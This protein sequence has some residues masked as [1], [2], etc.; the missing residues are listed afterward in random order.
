MAQLFGM[1]EISLRLLPFLCG[2]ALLPLAWAVARRVLAPRFALLALSMIVISPALVRESNNVKQYG[3]DAAIA[4][5][6][7]L[8]ALRTLQRPSSRG[9]WTLIVAAS[10]ACICSMTGIFVVAPA[11]LVLAYHHWRRG[12][13]ALARGFA[14]V[15]VAAMALTLVPYVRLYRVV[16][17]SQYMQDFWRGS[18]VSLAPFSAKSNNAMI[19][20]DAVWAFLASGRPLARGNAE[21]TVAMHFVTVAVLG[22]AAVGAF[23]LLGKK[24]W[25]TIVM[26]APLVLV[27][28]ASISGFYPMRAR[29]EVFL[30]L[31][32][33]V[34][35][36][37]GVEWL[38]ARLGDWVLPLGAASLLALGLVTVT[39]P[40]KWP[41]QWEE[42]RSVADSIALR[43][44]GEPVYVYANA[45]PAWLYYT[46][47]WSRP[48]T[49]RL[50]AVMKLIKAGGPAFENASELGPA[51]D[52][53]SAALKWNGRTEYYGRSSGVPWRP[54][55]DATLRPMLREWLA[56]ERSAIDSAAK[57]LVW[58]VF[59]HY[60]GTENQLL[61]LLE[62]DGLRQRQS[63][64]RRGAVA[65][66]Y[67][68]RPAGYGK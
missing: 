4:A 59:A 53:G 65:F 68:R 7:L 49:A 63:L 60:R 45:G 27:I 46:T 42:L 18:F 33:A 51:Q 54:Y 57:P 29:L 10:I 64:R 23:T 3:W 31:P 24:P 2:I 55:V 38:S 52:L 41:Y 47:H 21:L 36:G 12:A 43:P 37:A 48:D 11:L 9:A 26:A 1:G 35:S 16:A 40:S 25:I 34:L 14:W 22:L 20:A 6:V 61:D 39:V 30:I 44:V 5:L 32:F 66:L 15:C 13:Q 56:S 8:L 62:A 19:A 67:D 28:G 17:A 50:S 58:V